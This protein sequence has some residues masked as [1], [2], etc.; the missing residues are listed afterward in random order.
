MSYLVYKGNR[1]QYQNIADMFVLVVSPGFSLVQTMMTTTEYRVTG[2]VVEASL[3][4]GL[5]SGD[6]KLLY[7]LMI[8]E[9]IIFTPGHQSALCPTAT[10]T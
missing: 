8:H 10:N 5:I 3:R 6:S 9:A 2:T 7:F 4:D 1:T